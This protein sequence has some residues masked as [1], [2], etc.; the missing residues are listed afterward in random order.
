[1]SSGN[2]DQP[3]SHAGQSTNSD[4]DL[5]VLV[6][7]IVAGD[8]AALAKLFTT[9]RPRLWRMVNFRMHP[10]LRGRIDPDD[11]LQEA[12]IRATDR[13]S[14]FILDA[15]RSSFVWFRMIVIQALADLQRHHLGAEKRSA[16]KEISLNSAWKTDST[17]SLLSFHL[18]GHLTSPSSALSRVEVVRQIDTIVQGME[19]IDREVLALRHFE[20][21]TNGETAQVLGMSEQA[22][23]ARYIRALQRLKGILELIPDLTRNAP[24]KKS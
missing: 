13:I 6:D 18:Q 22:A 20:Q 15:S 3:S 17:S 11:V 24:S 5:S 8:K 1:M 10:Q 4:D 9:F 16:K 14:S 12:W 2:N 7:R 23:S 19:Q 21:L